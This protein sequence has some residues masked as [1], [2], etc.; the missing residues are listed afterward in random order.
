VAAATDGGRA[1]GGTQGCQA[2]AQALLL[3]RLRLLLLLLGVLFEQ[4]PPPVVQ[5]LMCRILDFNQL[6]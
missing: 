1:A 5:Q 6:Q 2:G 4:W 3:L